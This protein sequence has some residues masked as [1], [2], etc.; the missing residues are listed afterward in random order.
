M[1]LFADVTGS[2]DAHRPDL[3]AGLPVTRINLGNLRRNWL[4]LSSLAKDCQPMG[5]IKSDAYG[6]GLEAVARAL[7]DAGCRNLAVGGVAEGVILRKFLGD[8]GQEI[9]VLSLLGAQSPED[10]ASAVAHRITPLVASAGQAAQVSAAWSGPDPLPVAIKVDTGLARLGFRAH[11]MQEC[12]TALRSLANL[13]PAMLLSHLAFA[14]NPARDESVSGQAERFLAAYAAMRAFWP[15]IALSLANSACHLARDI[16]L[17]SLPPQVSRIGF[18]LYG[19]NPFSGTAREHL[20]RALLPVMEAAAPVLGVHD[21]AR[22][23]SVSYGGIFTAGKDMRIAVVGAGYADGLSRLL[24]GKGQVC[25]RGER[26]PRIGNLCM[27]MHMVDVG[28]VPGA[29]RGDAAYLLGGE[30]PGAI[31]MWD[32]AGEWGTIPYEVFTALGRNPRRY[33]S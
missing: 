14:D 12:I 28:R 9:S 18:A 21:L 8:T 10:A 30:G 24:S 2:A 13:R 1:T 22:G 33:Q 11:E 23:Q 4:F 7:L 31:S 29:A 3:P 17:G 32:I 26:C 20:G 15:D 5:V 27:Q 6:H 19:G 25:I 16:H